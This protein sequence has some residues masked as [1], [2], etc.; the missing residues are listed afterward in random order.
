MA[1]P[2]DQL[3]VE[4][5]NDFFDYASDALMGIPRGVEGAVQG[6]YNLADYLAFDSL[7]DYDTRFL[8]TSKTMAGG[9][10]E[11]VAQ[12]ATG[13]IPLFGAAGR[14]GAFA[15]AGK[16]AGAIR[17]VT[18]GAITDFTFFNGQE[19]RLSNLIQQ[20]PALQNP[21]NEFLA[22]DADEGEI[23]GRLKN[24]LEGLGLEAIGAGA[25]LAGLKVVKKVRDVRNNGGTPE[26]AAAA[27]DEVSQ[28]GRVFVDDE[29]QLA[30]RRQMEED[31]A[32]LLEGGIEVGDIPEVDLSKV[33]WDE[34]DLEEVIDVAP[35]IPREEMEAIEAGGKLVDEI[36]AANGIVKY[37]EMPGGSKKTILVDK[38]NPDRVVE[39]AGVIPKAPEVGDRFTRASMIEQ[40]KP[41]YVLQDGRQFGP[42]TREKLD[43]NIR[44]KALKPDAK[45]AQMG[46]KQWFDLSELMGG[47]AGAGRDVTEALGTKEELTRVGNT[48]EAMSQTEP[49]FRTKASFQGKLEDIITDPMTGF[50]DWRVEKERTGDFKFTKKQGEGEITVREKGDVVT[51]VSDLA[52]RKGEEVYQAVLQYAHNNNKIYKPSEFG[53]SDI[54]RV[55]TIGAMFSSALKNKTT[56][57]F[58]LSET[59]KKFFELPEGYKWGQDYQ[60]DLKYLA[61][62][63]RNIVADRLDRLGLGLLDD[64]RLEDFEY[65]F[66][67]NKFLDEEGEI[68]DQEIIDLIK[69]D[70]PEFKEGIGLSTFK[71]A[72]VTDTIMR[73]PKPGFRGETGVAKTALD[74]IFPM[75]AEARGPSAFGT[76]IDP[77]TKEFLLK[78]AES[79]K[80]KEKG[81]KETRTEAGVLRERIKP[82]DLDETPTVSNTLD[83]LTKN[84]KSPEVRNLAKGLKEIITDPEDLNVPIKYDPEKD[85]GGIA[86]RYALGTDDIELFKEAG[87]E[88]LVHEILHGV[89]ARKLAGHLK[90][91]YNARMAIDPVMASDL[92]KEAKAPKPVRELSA[93]YLKAFEHPS[94]DNKLY[95][96][97]DLDEFLA[98]AFTDKKLQELLSKI[99]VEDNRNLF[100]KLV[101]AVANLI[102]VKGDGNLLNKVI[103]DSAEIISGSR[104]ELAGSEFPKVLLEPSLRYSRGVP[105][106]DPKKPNEF[107]EAIPEKFRGYADELLKGGTPRLPRFALET[108]DDVVVLK[109]LLESYYKENPDKITVQGAVTEVGEEIEKQLMLQQ[110]KDTATKIAEA[111][112][113]QQSLRDQGAAVINNLTESIRKYDDAD[114]SGVAV[115]EIKN[116]FQQLLSVADV[117]RQLGRE[118]SLL[119]GARRENFRGS[120]IG[121]SE[122][123]FQIDGLRKEFANAS[124][125]DHKK[126]VNIIRE[127]ID[128]NDPEATFNKLFKVS[129]QAQGKNFLDMPTEYWMNAILSGPK[130]Q[131]VNAMGNSLTQIWSSIESV[132]GGIASGNMDVVR[133]VMASWSDKEM[134]KE[135]GKFAKKAFKQSDNVLDPEARAFSDRPS[136]AITGKRVSEALPGQGLSIKQEKGLDWFANNVIRIPSRLLMT[137]DEFFKQL[138]Y[139]RA[140][141]LKAAMSGIQQG[142]NDPKN[143][144]EYINKTLDGVITQGGRM[145]SKE[146]LAREA[147]EIAVTKGIKDT[148]EK[149]KFILD[150]V[151]KNFDEDKSALIQYAQEEARYLTFTKELE[152]G[153]G[154]TMQDFTNRHP[155][156]RFILPFVR[157]P[158]NILTFAIERTPLM[159]NPLMKQEFAILRKEFASADP[160]VKAQAR[161][162]VVTAGLVALGLVEAI[163]DSN[164]TITGGGPKNEK[165]KKALQ[166]AGWQPYSI[167]KGETYYSYQ[168]LDPLATPLGIVADLV[169]TGRDIS[170]LESKDSE[171]ILEHAYQSFIISLTRNITN[172]SYLTGIQNFTDALSN[173]ERFAGKFS[174]NFASSFVPNIISQMADSDEQVMRETR[175]VMDAVKRKL[176]AR[177]GLDA[178]RNA[179]GEEIMAETLLASP[180]QALNPIAVS[181]KK[182]DTVLQAMAELK[183]GFRNPIPNLGGDID[184]LD[185]ETENGQSAYDRWL[186]LSSEI[187]VKGDTLRQRLNRLVKSREFKDMTPLSEPGL[188]SPRIQMISSILDEYRKAARMKMLKEFP[189]LDRKYSLL[190]LARTRL[191]TG[192]SRE[193]VLALLTQ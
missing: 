152:E 177:G 113:I 19:A 58:T 184:L 30:A 123:D 116:N 15:K 12:F 6:A 169:E 89:T 181:T 138:A 55:R 156:F 142:V 24:V 29:A 105:K 78:G 75:T 31:E 115:A 59:H 47:K 37:Y 57:H 85:G 63:E 187:R 82:K 66:N 7:P 51:V 8:G 38:D 176:G 168:R 91:F 110:G 22:H 98:G 180:M 112:V 42:L 133:A 191:K 103:R 26:E 97:S 140:A 130:T 157:T 41:F 143:L 93:S 117:Y 35:R 33:N 54:N 141:R 20:Y 61:L 72:V 171:K 40:D 153:I 155:G 106:F 172:K 161:G 46:G 39:A 131:V 80:I 5:E 1:L 88:A 185:Y 109:D 190:T 134:F 126:M 67:K 17:G 193:D 124:G 127:N 114:G 62:A 186:Q 23:E 11:G 179:L 81:F 118:S 86:G 99:P 162:K 84:A 45:I 151:E 139:R 92:I 122:S 101:D 128:E 149:N 137:T 102:G 167:K 83:Q 129:K 96:M 69:A 146:G 107:L 27:A 2:E 95:P 44:T 34:V 132:L 148:T 173:P 79:R 56:K 14:I 28:G 192:V 49:L 154:K 175:G 111:R 73:G 74:R 65:D 43:L 9:L 188:P 60:Q 50:K 94:I 158:T 53:L 150:Y 4:D 120:K 189:E 178:K 32:A 108:G 87:E 174:K 104:K 68:S 144:A 164:G 36:E 16:A 13:F 48:W 170:A 136:V 100:Q 145:A 90:G 163:S 135:A 119:L 160:I 64:Y 165:E 71:R 18:A 25:F 10:V 52:K 121:L 21:V 76:E 147:N 70:D 3:P 183:H 182:D 77:K 125:S 166:A 159:V